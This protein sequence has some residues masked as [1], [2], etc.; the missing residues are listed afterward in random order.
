MT[1]DHA[2]SLAET[3]E[4]AMVELDAQMDSLTTLVGVAPESPLPAAIYRLQGA[5]TRAVSDLLGISSEWLEAWWLEHNYGERPMQ[6][7]LKGEP[8]RNITTLAELLAL[9]RGRSVG[10]AASLADKL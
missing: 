8:L 9:A 6:A 4:A 10:G 1:S 7:G 5:Y 2:L 3:W